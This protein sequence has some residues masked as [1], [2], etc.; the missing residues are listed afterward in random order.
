K[1]DQKATQRRDLGLAAP[2]P[3]NPLMQLDI[4]EE[5]GLQP[6]EIALPGEESAQDDQ[7]HIGAE[8]PDHRMA[9]RAQALEPEQR[10]RP[11]ELDAEGAALNEARIDRARGG[12]CG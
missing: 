1:A 7:R 6:L 5:N 3:G 9:D 10:L 12:E 2:Q 4:D 11:Q 8:A